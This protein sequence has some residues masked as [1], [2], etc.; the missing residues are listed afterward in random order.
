MIVVCAHGGVTVDLQ[1]TL[2]GG[3]A[4]APRLLAEGISSCA[5][6]TLRDQTVLDIALVNHL[7]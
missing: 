1:R 2:V 7:D 4:L 5:I 3:Q 6:T